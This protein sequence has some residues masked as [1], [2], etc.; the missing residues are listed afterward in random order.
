MEGL[1]RCAEQSVLPHA[2]PPFAL[3][4]HSLGAVLA[5]EL[6]CLLTH[7]HQLEPSIVF[8]SGTSAP[9]QR[10]DVRY[11]RLETD[12]ELVA[13]LEGLEGTPRAVL[14][15]PELM[16]LILPV[17]RADFTIC[18]RYRY[19]A[20]PRLRCP[21]Q[22]IIGRNDAT[23]SAERVAAWRTHTSGACDVAWLAGGH[24]FIHESRAAVLD[25]VRRRLA[26]LAPQLE[27]APVIA[28][29]GERE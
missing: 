29:P 20:R 23:T 19:R 11:A 28:S 12:A 5:Y 27:V 16:S 6:A 26:H 14:D 8:A 25:L 1:V 9:S 4:G 2:R 24:L 21:I 7:Q 10:D 15:S 18:G 13:E 22:V 3:Y 17:L